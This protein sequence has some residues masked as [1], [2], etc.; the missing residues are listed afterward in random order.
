MESPHTMNRPPDAK[1]AWERIQ[2]YLE[3]AKTQVYDEIK[4]YPRPIPACDQQFNYLL[5]QRRRIAQELDRLEEAS[6]ESSLGRDALELIGAFLESSQCL[7]EVA[8]Q[9]I[10][11]DLGGLPSG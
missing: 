5:E 1:S 3:N 6:Q 10:R 11:C 8:K 9:T 7:D 4:Q 2:T